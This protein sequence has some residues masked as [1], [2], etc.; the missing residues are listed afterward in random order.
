MHGQGMGMGTGIPAAFGWLDHGPQ[1]NGRELSRVFSSEAPGAA[2]ATVG[3][4]GRAGGLSVRASGHSEGFAPTVGEAGAATPGVVSA[5][6]LPDSGSGGGGRRST[7][8]V[9]SMGQGGGSTPAPSD[10]HGSDGSDEPSPS[11]V[12]PAP[13]SGAGGSSSSASASNSSASSS[14][15]A[16]NTSS[17]SSAGGP[18]ASGRVER[19]IG[20]RT[21]ERILYNGQ[22]AMRTTTESFERPLDGPGPIRRITSTEV[23][24]NMGVPSGVVEFGARDGDEEDDTEDVDDVAMATN[25]SGPEFMGAGGLSGIGGVPSAAL[26]GGGGGYLEGMIS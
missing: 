24:F 16:A 15:A 1:T 17:S 20:R 7:R 3:M 18:A 9:V 5:A 23:S 14:A 26:R 6:P 2:S 4:S 12:T 19:V 8:R 11:G 13:P 22:P 10:H 21:S 25:P